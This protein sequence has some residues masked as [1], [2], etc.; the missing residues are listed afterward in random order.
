[1]ASGG[2]AG[3]ADISRKNRESMAALNANNNST[4]LTLGALK[5]AT[6]VME[7]RAAEAKADGDEFDPLDVLLE[8]HAQVL[9]TL[10]SSLG[11][12]VGQAASNVAKNVRGSAPISLV[13]G[14]G[15]TSPLDAPVGFGK[16]KDKSWGRVAGEDPGYLQWVH[17]NGRDE[18]TRKLAEAALKSVAQ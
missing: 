2:F 14:T 3:A 1:M 18:D 12:D 15:D 16:Y 6:A 10:L 7:L 4:N 17:E 9:S 8:V 13:G 5:A 11:T